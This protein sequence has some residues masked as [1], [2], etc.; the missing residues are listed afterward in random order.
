MKAY[1][2]DAGKLSSACIRAPFEFIVRAAI[3]PKAHEEST[4]AFGIDLIS[5]LRGALEATGV[6]GAM[7][8]KAR[9]GYGSLVLASLDEE[10]SLATP[11]ELT[12]NI[13]TVIPGF[14]A[15]TDEEPVPYTAFSPAAR[16]YVG[17]D[18]ETSSPLDM[19]DR[20]GKEMVR[21][22]SW[23]YKEQLFN[24]SEKAE[25][26]YTTDHHLM[27]RAGRGDKVHMH[28]ARIVF[29]LPHNYG[30]KPSQQVEPGDADKRR[31]GSPLFLKVHQFVDNSVGFVMTFLP[32]EFLPAGEKVRVGKNPSVPLKK[33][34]LWKP[35]NSY[36]DRVTDTK[37]SEMGLTACH[38]LTFR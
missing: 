22:R 15:M 5:T 14:R 7:G 17:Q 21:E 11:K 23:G 9:K 32:A 24:F 20:M 37:S 10:P 35:I 31:R 8:S 2:R 27:K 36:I 26:N 33:K 34:G 16:V 6:F 13:K 3:K 4:E 18:K 19:L 30:K 29:G 1:G 25:R 28:P 38:D 12:K